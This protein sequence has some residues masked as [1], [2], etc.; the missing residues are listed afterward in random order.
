VSQPQPLSSGLYDEEYFRGRL[1]GGGLF[2]DASGRLLPDKGYVIL[3]LADFAPGQRVLDIGC[4]RGELALHAALAGADAHGLDYA[5]AGLRFARQL[6]DD[7]SGPER[8]RL[9]FHRGDGKRLPFRDRSFDRIVTSEFTEHVHPWELEEC[10]RECARVL[11]PDGHM[12]VHTAPN[13]WR[14]E[15]YYPLRALRARLFGGEAPDPD[16]DPLEE[17][18]H[19]N[20]HTPMY[21]WRSLNRHFCAR[22]FVSSPRRFFATTLWDRLRTANPLHLVRAKNLWAL[23]VPRGPGARARMRELIARLGA[24]RAELR[25]GTVELPHLRGRWSRPGW[26]PPALRTL[27]GAAGVTLAGGAGARAIEIDYRWI[28]GATPGGELELR[29]GGGPP[30][31]A[32]ARDALGTLRIPA[33]GGELERPRV[34]LELRAP[35]ELGI[36]ALRVSASGG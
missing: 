32:T 8:A 27:G 11:R 20:E 10:Y 9:H 2:L 14:Y 13:R 25:M 28:G 35:A 1:K 16:H 36:C 29:C 31:R 30:L 7:L 4:G 3:P 5:A 34:E 12:V 21:M 17:P 23:A 22:V 6:R 15:I 26:G 24:P 19:V 33:A 18:L